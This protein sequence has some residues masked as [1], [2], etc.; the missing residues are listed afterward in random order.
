MQVKKQVAVWNHNIVMK[1]RRYS[2]ARR[3]PNHYLTNDDLSSKVFYGIYLR[4]V[5]Q[6]HVVLMNSILTYMWR[7]YFWNYFYIPQGPMN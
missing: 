1:K 6:V 5:L 7:L 4:A 2:K 3:A